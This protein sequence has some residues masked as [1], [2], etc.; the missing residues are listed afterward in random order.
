M[1]IDRLTQIIQEGITAAKAGEITRARI[2]F[3]R[4][5]DLQPENPLAWL[6]AA[7]V[8]ETPVDAV[9]KLERVLQLDPTNVA[10][11]AAAQGRPI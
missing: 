5:I 10:A 2:A 8:A 3:R 1:S 6:W 7:G 4:A 9:R 11:K